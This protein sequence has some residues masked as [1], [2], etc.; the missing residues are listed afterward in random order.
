MLVDITAKYTV[1]ASAQW[2]IRLQPKSNGLR[3][4]KWHLR[5]EGLQKYFQ[6]PNSVK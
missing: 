3:R 2:K 5:T 6:C 4:E 1:T